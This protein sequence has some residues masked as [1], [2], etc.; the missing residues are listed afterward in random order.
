MRN[1]SPFLALSLLS[2]FIYTTSCAQHDDKK[3]SVSSETW[4]PQPR[5]ITPGNNPG[6]APSDALVLFDGANLD[7]WVSVIDGSAPKWTIK[8][9]VFTVA[10]G[11]KD[12]VTKKEFNDF[13]LHVEWRS[14]AEVKADKT[15]QDRGNSG[16]FLHGQYEVQVLDSYDNKT[17]VNGQAGAIYKQ[18]IPLVNA[19]KKPGEW[20]VYEIIFTAPHFNKEG[21][22]IV[23]AYVTVI[24]NGALAINHAAVWGS[25][26][27]VGF[28]I[29]KTYEKGPIRLQDHQSL[30][31]YRNIWIRDL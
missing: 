17:Y 4:E 6:N 20:Q 1:S 3:T 28:P 21:R 9:G 12:I 24:H 5:I 13:Q 25:T 26:E 18:H 31:S 22:V 27:N 16:I 11:T 7:Q 30:V 23:P 10:P 2:A 8:D 14:P 29:Y 15:G 19:S